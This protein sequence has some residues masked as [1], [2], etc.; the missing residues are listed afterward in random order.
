MTW[1]RD[2]PG[3]VRAAAV[4]A[5]VAG[6]S[7]VV[8]PAASAT[9]APARP[10]AATT[11]AGRQLSWRLVDTGTQT[12]FR[13]LSVVSRKVAWLGGYN[14]VVLRTV[15]GG[16]SWI[17]ASPAGSRSCSADTRSSRAGPAGSGLFDQNGTRVEQVEALA[18]DV[19]LRLGPRPGGDDG[20]VAAGGRGGGE[21]GRQ[22]RGLD[23]VA[24]VRGGGGRAGE[25]RDAPGQVEAGTAGG[26]PVAQRDVPH[27][28]DRRE[29]TLG[30]RDDLARKLFVGG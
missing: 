16:R 28:A 3:F 17:N 27:H 9:A 1:H 5:A 7:A 25:V 11:T 23:A 22:Q 24:A 19:L 13:G 15:D 18:L 6:L 20:D 14:G 21:P 12:H 2:H 30:S 4:C 26:D 29:I 10:G 8:V